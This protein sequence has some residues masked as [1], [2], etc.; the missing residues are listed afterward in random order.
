MTSTWA[1]AART[2]VTCTGICPTGTSRSPRE[3]P[4]HAGTDGRYRRTAARTTSG[5]VGAQLIPEPSTSS[6]VAETRTSVLLH[7][8]PEVVSISRERWAT[9]LADSGLPLPTAQSL[10]ELY[11]HQS[12]L[13]MEEF[14][15]RSCCPSADISWR[16]ASARRR[17]VRGSRSASPTPPRSTS[18]WRTSGWLTTR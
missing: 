10:A 17:P 18:S 12:E 2:L 9:T 11:A 16:R 8:D 15:R 5:R 7:R 6:S 3:V 14:I 1:C 13:I 4:S